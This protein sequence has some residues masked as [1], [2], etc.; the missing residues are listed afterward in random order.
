MRKTNEWISTPAKIWIFN[1]FV[2]LTVQY[3]FPSNCFQMCTRLAETLITQNHSRRIDLEDKAKVVA[4][5]WETDSLPRWLFCLGLFET[6]GF[7]QS[8]AE[9]E[10]KQLA[11]QGGW[12]NSTICFKKA[13]AKQL[14]QLGFCPPNRRNDL[15][16]VF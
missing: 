9:T 1:F 15:C 4:S 2:F 5:D 11:R 8:E 13:E 7:T 6:N 10:A 3:Y 12:L 14:A 16:L